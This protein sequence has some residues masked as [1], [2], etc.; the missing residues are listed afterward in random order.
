MNTISKIDQVKARPAVLARVRPG[1]AGGLS[2]RRRA[3]FV[4]LLLSI[5]GGV[6]FL[7]P[8]GRTGHPSAWSPTP[9]WLAARGTGGTPFQFGSAPDAVRLSQS[10][11]PF[12]AGSVIPVARCSNSR[13]GTGSDCSSRHLHAQSLGGVAICGRGPFFD[14]MPEGCGFGP[15]VPF[16]ADISFP[17]DPYGF[18]FLETVAGNTRV[19]LQYLYTLANKGP[20]DVDDVPVSLVVKLDGA[21]VFNGAIPGP[22][23]IA[24]DGKGS[25]S[26]IV[27]LNF[28]PD[29]KSHMVSATF[30]V[31]NGVRYTCGRNDSPD[32]LYAAGSVFGPNQVEFTTVLEPPRAA[33]SLPDKFETFFPNE[34]QDVQTVT[35]DILLSAPGEAPHILPLTVLSDAGLEKSQP[36]VTTLRGDGHGGF[37]PGSSVLPPLGGN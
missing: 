4:Y 20:L 19:N 8:F 15:I 16:E 9:G 6:V 23:P 25:R 37:A 21:V 11:G 30:A 28:S 35:G 29:G 24:V 3:I 2:D 7:F 10:I 22:G 31:S 18:T 14:P 34:Q 33:P 13:I 1:S 5:T 36:S 17:Q 27:I 12:P 26:D 32:E